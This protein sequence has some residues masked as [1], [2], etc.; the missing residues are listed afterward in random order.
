MTK[1]KFVPRD[2]GH[3][4]VP[5]VPAHRAPGPSSL[6]AESKAATGRTEFW[7][8]EPEPM[9]ANGTWG[10]SVYA[11]KDVFLAT[12]NYSTQADAIHGRTDMVG[13]LKG[14]ILIATAES[15]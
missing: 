8:S 9:A 10:F 5:R 13:V 12:F 7:L 4:A 11:D 2:A 15:R 6:V 14:A 1:H 3:R